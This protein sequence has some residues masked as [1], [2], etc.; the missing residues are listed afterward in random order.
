MAEGGTIFLDEIGEMPT[1]MQVK[2]L[3]VLQ[4][5]TYEPLGSS[6]T[7]VADVRFISATNRDLHQMV[8]EGIFRQDLF[9][10][11]N[12]MIIQIPPLR[13]RPED[14][15]LLVNHFLQKYNLSTGK[16]VHSVNGRVMDIFMDAPWPGN[17]RQLEHVIEH[18]F[19]LVKGDEIQMEHLPREL[20]VNNTVSQYQLPKQP[21]LSK[22]MQ[23][24]QRD[25]I[26]SCLVKN[27]W[28]KVTAAK[29]L[30]ISRTTLWRRIKELDIPE[31][32]PK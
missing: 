17:V 10:R 21:S 26:L 18:A 2:L 1:G 13:E 4:E 5:K 11:I 27:N 3:R 29:E 19:V 28:N 15:P 9:Y 30:G 6:K 20:R 7:R 8:E 23:S 14:I 22:N 25:I 32:I 24:T 16:T 12:T 31:A